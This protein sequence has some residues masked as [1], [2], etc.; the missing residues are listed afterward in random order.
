MKKRVVAF[1]SMTLLASIEVS[2]TSTVTYSVKINKI[3]NI[4]KL[5]ML[6]PLR[7]LTVT[8]LT[9]VRFVSSLQGLH[10]GDTVAGVVRYN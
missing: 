10:G 1:R 2:F 3:P 5:C 8:V 4:I 6:T 9:V 7:S